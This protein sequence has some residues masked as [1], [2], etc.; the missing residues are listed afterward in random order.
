[1]RKLHIDLNLNKDQKIFFTSDLH[2]GH[3]NVIRFCHRPFADI[4]EMSEKLIENW[5]SVVGEND[6]VFDL[7]DMF[8]FDGRHDVKHFVEKLNGTIYKVPGNHD[9]DCKTLFSLC[10][11]DKVEVLDDIN[12]VWITGYNPEVPKKTQE[13]VVC[14][15]PLATFPHWEH[16]IQVF[17]HIHSGP[18]SENMVDIPGKDLLLN[19][20]QYDVGVDNNNFTPVE[21]REI[22]KKLGLSEK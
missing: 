20:N 7:G 8:W 10:S 5:N 11:A 21:F 4:K 17:G 12:T 15:Y 22:L 18:L 9:M 1:M 13:V 14:H 6:I 19:K 3:R 2:V 16:A